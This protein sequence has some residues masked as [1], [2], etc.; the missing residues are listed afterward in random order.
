MLFPNPYDFSLHKTTL[1][2]MFCIMCECFFLY[3][4]FHTLKMD[5]NF[6]ARLKRTKNTIRNPKKEED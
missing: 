2:E 1:K 5:S 6:T 3:T 4:V